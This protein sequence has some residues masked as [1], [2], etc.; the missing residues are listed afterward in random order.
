MQIKK[1]ILRNITS[2]KLRNYLRHFLLF[3]IF[4]IA[5]SYG[6]VFN[7]LGRQP[8]SDWDEGIY[9][10]NALE[11]SHNGNY[12]VKYFC[13]NPDMIAVEPPLG[14]W[15]QTLS[16]KLF[17]Y[18]E[19]A[20]RLPSA[21]AAVFVAFLVLNFCHKELNNRVLGYL[22]AFVLLTSPGY[23]GFH[24]VHTADLDSLLVLF[25]TIYVFSFYKYLKYSGSKYFYYALAG[26]LLAFFTKSTAGLML[27]LP[28]FIYSVYKKKLRVIFSQ[29]EIYIGIM[30]FLFIVITII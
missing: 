8:I 1:L 5:V 12:L 22:S 30:I 26:L 2:E 7:Q 19:V 27:L 4:L 6:T 18:N 20:H 17:G 14:A 13:G 9:T 23:D 3:D 21:I 11:M 24:I 15:L 25:S 29:K 16:V 28:L 10:T